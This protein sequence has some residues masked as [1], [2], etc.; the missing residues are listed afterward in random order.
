MLKIC[1]HHATNRCKI[2]LV[3]EKKYIKRQLK[4]ALNMRNK[5]KKIRYAFKKFHSLTA[6]TSE[7]KKKRLSQ[8]MRGTRE[9]KILWYK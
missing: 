7:V 8:E 4:I 3:K 2:I 6:D 5:I 1:G 9:R